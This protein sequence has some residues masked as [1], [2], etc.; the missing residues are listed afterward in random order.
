V[1]GTSRLFAAMIFRT[2]GGYSVLTYEYMGRRGGG[3][4]CRQ[5]ME[6]DSIKP[7]WWNETNLIIMFV[8]FYKVQTIYMFTFQQRDLFILLIYSDSNK[9]FILQK[10]V[11]R[12]ITG[13]VNRD[14]CHEVFK[15]LNILTLTLQHIY[16]V[17]C[18]VISNQDGF[19]SVSEMH[20]IFTRQVNNFYQPMPKSTLYQRGIINMGIEIYNKLPPFI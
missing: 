13:L 5:K 7:V 12:T 9:I 18:F 3:I 10:E 2:Q 8:S 19:A 6:D 4:E 15:E 17:L 11:L 20:R 1:S 16:S 14:T